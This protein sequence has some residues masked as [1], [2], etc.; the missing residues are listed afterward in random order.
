MQVDGPNYT[1]TLQPV[2]DC[3][4]QRIFSSY[5]YDVPTPTVARSSSLPVTSPQSSYSGQ[6]TRDQGAMV[7]YARSGENLYEVTVIESGKSDEVADAA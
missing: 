6:V 5:V 2:E 3:K 1:A 4:Q 7:F